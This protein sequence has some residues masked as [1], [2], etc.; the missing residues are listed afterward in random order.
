[1]LRLIPRPS[2][3][4]IYNNKKNIGLQKSIN[5]A[6]RESKGRYIVRVDSDDYVSD[7]FLFMMS[8]FLK[9]NRNYHAVCVDYNLISP[10]EKIIK[11]KSPTKK[12]FHVPLC[13]ERK[14]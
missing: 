13:T 3:N 2:T 11:R 9:K 5:N 8:F 7:Y 1:M 10:N 12:K 6:I 14:Y 4:K